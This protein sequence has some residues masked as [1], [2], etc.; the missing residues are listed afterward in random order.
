MN[1][2]IECA[3]SSL[4][5]SKLIKIENIAD[6]PDNFLS[7][8][9]FMG[10]SILAIKKLLPN[11]SVVKEILADLYNCYYTSSHLGAKFY[12]VVPTYILSNDVGKYFDLFPDNWN[13][14]LYREMA[15][16]PEWNIPDWKDIKP[17][18][19]QKTLLGSGYYTDSFNGSADVNTL[20]V[21]LDNGDHL[22]CFFNCFFHK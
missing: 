13:I 2:D 11:D 7:L 19:V 5:K 9:Y 6:A 1:L 21:Q 20:A 14:K 10:N 12:R 15:C 17:N 3:I 8:D 4:D 16:D 22:V 18:S